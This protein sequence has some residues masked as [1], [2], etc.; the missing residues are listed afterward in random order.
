MSD[1]KDP[2]LTYRDAGVDI[3][4]QDDGLRRIK[5]MLLATRT[6]GVLA[7]LGSFGG[8]FAPDLAGMKEP[9]LV[10]SCDGVG[11]KLNVAF[12][13][14]IHDTVGRDL[15]NHC[16]NDILVQG[17]A[18]LFFLDYV[19]TGRLVPAVLASIVE[20]IAAGCR[21]NGCALLG[22]ETAEMPGFYAD[23]TYDLAGF[24]VGMV[25]K[26]A[27]IDGRAIRP[28]DGLYA[29]PSAGL[30]TNGYSL[31]RK[32]FFDVAKARP[33]DSLPGLPGTVGATLLAPHLSYLAP[34]RGALA[35]RLV[36]GLAHIT[37]GG[38]TDNLPRVL[39]EG[40]AARIERGSWPLPPVFSVMQRIGRVADDEMYRAFNM[41]VG[42]ACVVDPE[43]AR[44]FEAHLDSASQAFFRIG[45]IVDGAR[46]VIYA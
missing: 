11:T 34:L 45:R 44:A 42:M 8:M 6:K 37:G 40:T 16:V 4:A 7:D 38:L 19:A 5:A 18:P 13:T 33:D 43:L 22:G 20:G 17:A 1:P 21:E 3:D 14:G 27:V 9:V 31:A 35:S 10:A 32:I 23:G 25:D 39:P 12:M 36:R 26:P 46:R 15:V 29:L 30:H 28:G 24:I 2:G 41:G